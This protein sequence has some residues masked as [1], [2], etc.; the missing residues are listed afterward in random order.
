MA[1]KSGR[2]LVSEKSRDFKSIFFRWETLLVILFIAV[3]I[4]NISISDKYLSV[5]GLFTATNTFLYSAFLVLPMCYILLLGE[6]DI[7]VGSIV[8]LSACSLGIAY[9]AGLPMGVAVL[10]C[11]LVGTI[12]GMINGLVLTKFTELNPMIVTLGSQILFR[13]IAEMILEDQATGG[14][15]N[16]KWFTDL[17]WGKIGGVIPYL[18]VIFVVCAVVFGIIMH[19][20]TFGRRMYAIGSNRQAAL[21][22][23]IN[24]QGIR[25][26][27]YTVM[28]LFS[29]VTAIFL[30][31]QMGSARSNVA[32]GFEL[33]AIGIA[34]LGG[35][36]SDGGKGNF[37]GAMIAIF[38]MGFLQYGLG[39]VNVSAQAMLVIKGALLILAVM[40]P[41]LL[42]MRKR[43]VVKKA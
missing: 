39:L 10:V 21:Y 11:L 16:V 19:K 30:A 8:A 12:C 27:V 22:S 6:I 5:K 24:V 36:M 23:G 42:S 32:S 17:F 4:M 40:T 31:S 25:F 2:E 20:T 37:I 7:S 29:G 43:R 9:N 26:T 33:T 14:F 41:N 3:N 15:T 18:F 28:G 38:I 35:I 1:G 34:V 13:G